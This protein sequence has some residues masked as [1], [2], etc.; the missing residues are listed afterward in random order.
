MS[1][2]SWKIDSSSTESNARAGRITTPNGII[3][4]PAFIF[5]GTKAA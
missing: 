2:F 3:E 1:K 4:T 5:C